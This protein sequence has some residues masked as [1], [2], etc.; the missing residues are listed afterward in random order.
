MGS[1]TTGTLF[2][3][4]TPRVLDLVTQMTV[5]NHPV[6]T[7]VSMNDDI[8]RHA[9]GL[10]G[11]DWNVSG[12]SGFGPVG[13][14]QAFPLRYVALF[15]FARTPN[16]YEAHAK[17]NTGLVDVFGIMDDC[18]TNTIQSRHLPSCRWKSYL[19]YKKIKHHLRS[20]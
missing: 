12:L 17:A 1:R 9:M 3:T 8:A 2:Y 6:G 5:F 14:E 11:Y 10:F 15:V 20:L 7:N 19:S 4:S 18:Q 16:L 13:N